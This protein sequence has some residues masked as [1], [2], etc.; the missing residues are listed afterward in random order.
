M[1]TYLLP[2]IFCICSSDFNQIFLLQSKNTTKILGT[3]YEPATG[4]D[5]KVR[6]FALVK[7]QKIALGESKVVGITNKFHIQL[8]DSAEFL[9]FESEGYRPTIMPIRRIGKIDEDFEF[10]IIVPMAANDSPPLPPENQLHWHFTTSVNREVRFRVNE[11]LDLNPLIRHNYLY[12]IPMQPGKHSIKARSPDGRLLLNQEFILESGLTIMDVRVNDF[13]DLKLANFAK[14][15]NDKSFDTRILY[16][17]QSKFELRNE[18]KAT[19]DSI[20]LFLSN[21]QQMVVH[22]TGYTDNVGDKDKN[23]ILSEYRART[24]KTYLHQKGVRSEQVVVAWKGSD[25]L[26]ASNDSE[27]AKVK[28]RRVVLQ[29]LPK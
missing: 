13:E 3:C 11:I 18:V 12:L 16:F 23:L 2:L 7:E 25:G 6:A 26:A 14:A 4:R 27:Q 9:V 15:T 17:D 19:L 28:N 22:V 24:V 29:I 10:E 20:A 5:L 1:F 8:P 21:Q